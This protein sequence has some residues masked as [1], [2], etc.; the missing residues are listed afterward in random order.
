MNLSFDILA[1]GFAWQSKYFKYK[2][3][4]T[5]RATGRRFIPLFHLHFLKIFSTVSETSYGRMLSTKFHNN[6]KWPSTTQSHLNYALKF[7]VS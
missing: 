3:S 5:N 4:L 2:V 7:T 1:L 6:T